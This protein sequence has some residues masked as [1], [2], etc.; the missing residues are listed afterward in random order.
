MKRLLHI[1]PVLALA[2]VLPS[3]IRPSSVE[4]FRKI[5]QRDTL[6]RYAFTVD[7]SDSLSSYDI[8]FCT[9]VDG[10]RKTLRFMGDIQVNALWE[11]PTGRLY[12]ETVY[13]PKDSYVEATAFSREFLSSYRSG[14]VPKEHGV[15]K[16]FLSLPTD[17]QSGVLGMGIIC[18]KEELEK[19]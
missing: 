14:L 1:L 15:W 10:K 11:S 13:I 9:R 6:G 5:T 16:L 8:S 18:R 4:D 2:F 17:T 3:C 19:E 12:S 7:M